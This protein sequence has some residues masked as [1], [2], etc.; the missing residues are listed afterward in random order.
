VPSCSKQPEPPE[1]LL[2]R[3]DLLQRTRILFGRGSRCYEAELLFT[4]QKPSA[5]GHKAVLA[6]DP[7]L[8]LL[9]RGAWMKR[10]MLAKVTRA[11]LSSFV[12]STTHA[13][14]L[15]ETK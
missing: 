5:L 14:T 9:I 6:R 12:V 13:R 4:V 3:R 11:P 10:K 7:F 1:R 8:D 2:N 15:I